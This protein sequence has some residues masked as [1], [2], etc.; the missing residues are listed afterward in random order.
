[1]PVPYQYPEQGWSTGRMRKRGEKVAMK[2][3]P[4]PT[5]EMDRAAGAGLAA[6]GGV[7]GTASEAPGAVVSGQ[8]T[9]EITSQIAAHKQEIQDGVN[10][11]AQGSMDVLGLNKL[12]KKLGWGRVEKTGEFVDPQGNAHVIG[13][14]QAEEQK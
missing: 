12:L 6:R 2:M 1:M 4:T 14:Q 9:R 10:Q 8:M 11:V 5:Y 3:G 13:P 7:F